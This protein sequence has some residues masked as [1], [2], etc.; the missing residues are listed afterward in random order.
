MQ[1]LSKREPAERSYVFVG[2]PASGKTVYFT[3]AMD[4]L[5]SVLAIRN[6]DYSLQSH[7][8]E[9]SRRHT[10]SVEEMRKG[11]WPQQTAEPHKL[12]YRLDHKLGFGKS[13]HLATMEYRL[14]Y[15]DYPG[16]VFLR[17][18]GDDRPEPSHWEEEAAQ[19]K[20]D[21]CKAK[22]VFVVVDTVK[23][24][25][26]H[27]EQYNLQLFRLFDYLE[28]QALV[29]RI[30]VVFTKRD[31]FG[32]DHEFDPAECLR[33]RYTDAWVFLQRLKAKTFFVSAVDPHF[34]DKDGNIVPP[35]GYDTSKSHDLL[36]PISWI[37]KLPNDVR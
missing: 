20:V 5:R 6:R 36:A 10:K 37:L 11:R 23:L 13:V 1:S 15:H 22:G 12:Q 27:D 26:R 33:D 9:T 8:V 24:H 30:A 18:F 3:C 2:P 31:L 7:D 25:D 28:K 35:A 17:A 14:A 16:E 32:E 29:K 21:I 34:T 19:L 4:R